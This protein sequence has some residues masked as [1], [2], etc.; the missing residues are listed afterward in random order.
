M[1]YSSPLKQ[2]SL[3]LGSVAILFLASGVAYAAWFDP[4]C[5]PTDL[6][7][8]G[9]CNTDTPINVS[10]TAQTKAGGFGLRQSS[11]LEL[12]KEFPTTIKEER[13]G[14]IFYFN[15]G[16]VSTDSKPGISL[17][18][19][20]GGTAVGNR[21][22]H[23]FDNLFVGGTINAFKYNICTA[24]GSCSPITG[25]AGDGLWT[26]NYNSTSIFPTV[27]TQIV[28]I[29]TNNPLADLHVKDANN[30]GQATFIIQ[31]ELAKPSKI[32]FRADNRDTYSLGR[33][34]SSNDLVFTANS[35]GAPVLSLKENGFVGIGTNSANTFKLEIAG[36]TGP[37]EDNRFDLGSR[38]KR[39]ANLY[40][41]NIYKCSG[42]GSCVEISTLGGGDKWASSTVNTNNIY[43]KNL[44]GNVGVG[45]TNPP[46]KFSVKGTTSLDGALAVFGPTSISGATTINNNLTLG[47]NI[48]IPATN[49]VDYGLGVPGRYH[50]GTSA[51]VL[52]AG[53]V[54][55]A[56]NAGQA[57]NAQALDVMGGGVRLGNRIVRLFDNVYIPGSVCNGNGTVCSTIENLINGNGSGGSQL[58][59]T[60]TSNAIYNNNAGNVG[61][62]V[63][64]PGNKLQVNG[65]LSVTGVA[66]GNVGLV[67]SD[68]SNHK[69]IQ[70]YG[71]EPLVL[72]PFSN[73]VGIGTIAPTSFKLQVKG[74]IGP[75]TDNTYSL[76]SSAKRWKNLYAVNVNA[77]TYNTCTTNAAGARVCSPLNV[78]GDALWEKIGTTQNI[79]SKLTGNVGIG[80]T[81]PQSKLS[82][83]GG[84][85]AKKLAIYEN[86]NATSP[87]TQ[88]FYGFGL[89]QSFL[90]MWAGNSI[91]LSIY[92]GNGNVGI[93]T[94]NPSS[95]K[96]QT[97]GDVGPNADITYS[98]GSTGL[99][100]KNVFAQN[101]I[102]TNICTALGNCR[103][104]NELVDQNI[105]TAGDIISAKFGTYYA[106][107]GLQWQPR[108]DDGDPRI[109]A[110]KINLG[111]G[112]PDA[113]RMT[114]PTGYRAISGGGS[115]KGIINLNANVRE[116][117]GNWAV[118]CGSQFNDIQEGSIT[119]LAQ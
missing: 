51:P 108:R 111:P 112:R 16:V 99:R 119:C 20:G 37:S 36:N 101:I 71:T 41:S 33:L 19:F 93:G 56:T 103:G 12:G 60:S 1:K 50:S 8:P 44:T 62:G 42:P 65:G 4:K 55:Y 94:L 48:L 118:A 23:L 31:S 74:D 35:A 92:A 89:R 24:D 18:I 115:C 9:P 54:R 45:L 52:A 90:D 104:I 96:L 79:K 40:A 110:Q 95:F 63:N 27:L 3:I 22:V 106:G 2:A 100:W 67:L 38:T 30:S 39:W 26:K 11:I 85:T 21:M 73:N 17:R 75:E 82:L 72:N 15:N 83:G 81:N 86:P 68:E 84:V 105:L 29:G 64:N 7:G 69:S 13:A 47:G 34:A 97:A 53:V 116:A 70:A 117:S 49:Y 14:R 80:T 66:V 88:N 87:E 98:L 109:N 46:S 58:W 32:L 77:D 107:D 61:I 28:G 113:M 5:T 6:A 25:G 43:S 91:A 59:A 76:G 57:G 102:A 114:C 10:A 78:G